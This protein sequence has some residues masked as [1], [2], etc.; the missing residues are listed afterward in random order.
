[1]VSSILSFAF[2]A[3]AAFVVLTGAALC[4]GLITGRYWT[5]SSDSLRANAL[6]TAYTQSRQ[7]SYLIRR[8][9]EST[10]DGLVVQNM[11]GR[12]IWANPAYCQMFGLSPEDMIGRN[13]L[14]FV[15]PDDD[16]PS[17]EEIENFHYDS[18]DP[19]QSGLHLWRNKRAD[20]ELFWNQISVSFRVAP[21]GTEHAILACRDVTDQVERER[22][23]ENIRRKLEKRA[24]HDDL[25]GIANRTA[26]MK[27]AET[28]LAKAAET[29][30]QIGMIRIDLDRFKD[31]NDTYGHPAGDATLIHMAQVFRSSL[32]G[33]DMIA[34]IGGDEFVAVCPDISNLEDL[35]NIAAT[36]GRA[37]ARPFPWNHGT[38]RCS[39]SFGVAL[40]RPEV[41]SAEELLQHS[42][43][44][45]YE[46]KRRRRGT[47]TAYSQDMHQRYSRLAQRRDAFALALRN[48]EMAFFFQPTVNLQSG[49]ISGFETLVRWNHPEEGLLSPAHILPLAEELGLMDELD[50]AAMRAG[51]AMKRR[52]S[53]NGFPGLRIGLNVSPEGLANRN[54]VR[55]LQ[56]MTEQAGIPPDEIVVEVLETVMFENSPAAKLHAD[57]IHE[58]HRLGFQTMLDDFGI[59]HAGLS[60]LAQLDLTGVKVDRSL[61]A[62]VL[63]DKV[64]H[65]ILQ[66]IVALCGDLG[67]RMIAEGVEDAQTAAC[68]RD[69]GVGTLQGY[70]ISPPLPEAK[71]L[72]WLE[73]H[74]MPPLPIGPHSA[75]AALNLPHAIKRPMTG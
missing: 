12:I 20:G 47:V 69:M 71:V 13:P 66:T 11:S 18:S 28:A 41:L 1:M 62:R 17:P 73:T 37:C 75:K 44:A 9:V 22:E 26:L 43:F 51:L 24:L 70:W 49:A 7:D 40:S 35:E 59:G 42:D 25:T 31:I 68:L 63:V 55:T 53:S 46:T 32:R 8:V 16:T 4:L 67:L 5:H 57:R 14:E 27:F 33:T 34:R 72:G 2:S 36:L 10:W 54:Y 15:L 21:D 6:E 23:R 19:A 48:D 38:L 65:R 61:A 64:S 39:A 74:Q 52:L 56:S 50:L 60:H 58:L 30:H 29:G 3:P 45:L